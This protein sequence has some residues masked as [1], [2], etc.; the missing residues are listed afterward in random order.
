MYPSQTNMARNGVAGEA[1]M[2]QPSAHAIP[3]ETRP[4]TA[5]EN[6]PTIPTR[7]SV[8]ASSGSFSIWATPPKANS[9][10]ALV[11]SPRERATRACDISCA[12]SVTKN[13]N[14][15]QHRER[16][17]DVRAP[18][19]VALL[20]LGAQGHGD[21]Q[22]DQEPTVVQADFNAEELAE[23]NGRSHEPLFIL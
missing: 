23:P 17:N 19:R 12:S 5:L 15:R 22:R 7:N 1:P 10:M 11:V 6:G 3:S 2:R 18:V 9:V 16:P 8:L 14:G 20:E 13:R 21:Q 4:I